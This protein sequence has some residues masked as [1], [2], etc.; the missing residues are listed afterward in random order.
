MAFLKLN[1][2]LRLAVGDAAALPA[3]Q[4]RGSEATMSIVS[5]PVVFAKDRS[6]RLFF[7]HC[8]SGSP[9]CEAH[10]VKTIIIRP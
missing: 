1:A 7:L 4:A 10:S 6:S 3:A 8:H 9:H 2:P 5:P